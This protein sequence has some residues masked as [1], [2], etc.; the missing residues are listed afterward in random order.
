MLSEVD[1]AVVYASGEREPAEFFLDSLINSSRFDL[2]LGFF[3]TSG[4]RALAL[5]F[6]S[7]IVN[8]GTMRISINNILSQA[9]K[10]SIEKGLHSNPEELI[11][12]NL[13]RDID[14]LYA[15]LSSY[16]KHFFNCI[17][18]L[19]A[20][21][22]LEI[23][24]TTP[25][26][27]SSGI[28]HQ[29]FG[30]FQ[31]DFGG[32]VAFNGSANFSS[33]AMFSNMET[34]SCYRSWTNDTSD[35]QRIDYFRSAFEQIWM[36]VNP[37]LRIIPINEVNTLIRSRFPVDNVNQL[38]QEEI[39]L[40]DTTNQ[41]IP[42][43]SPGAELY[44]KKLDRMKLELLHHMSE[45]IPPI[46]ARPQLK[47][48]DGLI[49]YPHQIAAINAWNGTEG[50]HN[51]A[52]R[53]GFLEMATGSGKTIAA[54]CIAAGLFSE[55]GR[56]AV[57]IV[58][59]TK[60]LIEQWAEEVEKFNILPI[61]AYDDNPEWKK[62]SWNSVRAYNRQ[63]I[64]HLFLIIT[65]DSFTTTAFKQLISELQGP[66]LLIADEAHN[67][68]A[69][70]I[71][72]YLPPQIE[73]RLALSATPRRYFDEE[74]TQ[75]LFDYFGDSI[76]K[77]TLK[78]AIGVCL[79]PYDYYITPVELNS[80]E[81]EE[82]ISLTAKI[83]KLKAA[84]H[85]RS[86]LDSR[87]NHLLIK[88]ARIIST[89]NGKIEA[90]SKKFD[91]LDLRNVKHTFVYTSDKDPEQSI[92]V[93]RLLQEQKR[94]LVHQFTEEETSNKILRK[95][96]IRRFAV[97]DD[98]QVLVAKRCLDEGV[99]IPPTRYGYFLAHTTNPRQYIQRRGRLLRKFPG[100]DSAIIND[101]MVIPPVNYTT[102]S[103][104]KEKNI[105]ITELRRIIEFASNAR[106]GARAR[107]SIFDIAKRYG[108][109]DILMG[110]D[111]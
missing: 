65:N 94:L 10:D 88:R 1:F 62:E 90:L 75:L 23:K 9:D 60:V 104:Q 5:G 76:Y 61:K 4:F 20:S 24:A 56:L 7:F 82:Y 107:L 55:L 70:K 34:I 21:G 105:I 72:K 40:I 86:D 64:D 31:D 3:S 89:A 67:L 19:I 73:Y 26:D 14:Q 85:D 35:N 84:A 102:D 77:F 59:P 17:S 43:N 87:L 96:L 68:G 2:A 25:S 83:G 27:S 41:I 49:L 98:L 50:K 44:R 54:L 18:W 103:D 97:G 101:F 106:N 92:A 93:V 22:K 13:C 52:R 80:D 58:A 29:K 63:H 30:I 100:K 16:D 6:A 51:Q 11:A 28:A 33:F 8:G 95:E 39:E 48:P 108:V 74:G 71:V 79:T 109:D 36:G 12:G 69:S 42:S 57:I 47:P 66:V 46:H 78:E 45:E 38:V 37:K 53:A 15:T 99:D 91:E 111:L 81:M 32:V 110:G